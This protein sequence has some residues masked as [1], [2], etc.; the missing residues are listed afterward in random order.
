MVS[1]A[2]L[3]RR[4][5]ASAERSSE[6]MS[7]ASAER[8]KDDKRF[9][10]ALPINS[11]LRW[12]FFAGKVVKSHH[13]PEPGK[14]TGVQVKAHTANADIDG[15]E[16][17]RDVQICAGERDEAGTPHHVM[18]RNFGLTPAPLSDPPRPPAQFTLIDRLWRGFLEGK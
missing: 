6:G 14:P 7:L 9:C 17:E 5:C 12:E 15:S 10:T 16:R 11:V 2:W 3:A 8:A 1:S 18:K 13:A 4:Y